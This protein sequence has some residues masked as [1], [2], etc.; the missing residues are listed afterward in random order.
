SPKTLKRIYDSQCFA[1]VGTLCTHLIP[2]AEYG[3]R[4][5][6]HPAH[7]SDINPWVKYEFKD[8]N[9]YS[10]RISYLISESDELV[11]VAV[12]H[13]IRSAYSKFNREDES[14]LKEMDIKLTND[15]F[16][17]TKNGICFH[18]LDE[19]LL[20]E[21]GFVEDGKI[22]CKDCR[23]DF[24]VL[25]HISDMDDSTEILIKKYLCE[26]GK[27][28]V[29][30]ENPEFKE[31]EP[32]DY[33]YIISNCDLND[34]IKAQPF[35]VL[36]KETELFYQYRVISGMPF[37]TVFNSSNS[38]KVKNTFAFNEKSIKSFIRLDLLTLKQEILPLEITL[39]PGQAMILF[40]SEQIC[41]KQCDLKE[42][43][44]K[45]NNADV[46]FQN[47]FLT[48]DHV[49][50]SEDGINYSELLPISGVFAMLLEKRYKGKIYF[51]YQFEVKTIPNNLFIAA[52]AKNDSTNRINGNEFKFDGQYEHE[53]H[54]KTANISQYIHKGI[55]E[56][57]TC[58]DWYQSE[59]VYYALFGENVTEGLKNCIVY[60][61][62]LENIYLFGKFGVYTDKP[63]TVGN[64]TEYVRSGEFYIDKVT[65]TVKQEPIF[66]GYPF[67][68]G[69][70][71]LTQS[72]CFDSKNIL[73][74]LG[75]SW[76]V[77]YI[78][79]NGDFAGKLLF[80][81]KID[82]SRFTRLGENTIEIEL[83][84]SN[85]NLL[86]P[87][88]A[89]GRVGNSGVSPWTFDLTDTWNDCKSDMYDDD[90]CLL[91]FDIQ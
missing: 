5:K 26:N 28:L 29:L 18:F 88:H 73:F 64:P 59:E 62:E 44:F 75:G 85:Y 12:L 9:D 30:G 58:V 42:Y 35:T 79:V 84:I 22:C 33:S 56:Y 3:Q 80:E 72:V 45:L 11:N 25:P 48:I 70:F 71:K 63:F 1:G 90:Y 39:E 66:E 83:I 87:H 46:E 55:N 38:C 14:S 32:H 68:A 6:D 8:F 23:Y 16:M 41:E 89:K 19:T 53:K 24:L 51:K 37:I 20:K 77:A 21:Y 74:E 10:S 31:G 15:C 17:L 27:I 54:L 76:S 50:Y 57:I 67:F 34:I 52:E 13:P 82:I 81:R 47:N 7:Y 78:T 4:S 2:Y 65:D 61:S 40:P 36:S 49:R 91:K 60:N 86:G 69:R 43:K